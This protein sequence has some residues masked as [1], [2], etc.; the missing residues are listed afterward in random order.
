MVTMVMIGDSIFI[1]FGFGFVIG[2][3]VAVRL[4][5]NNQ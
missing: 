1:L 5:L 4:N 3:R 2:L